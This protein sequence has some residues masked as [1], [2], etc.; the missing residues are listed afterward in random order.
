MCFPHM[1]RNL[2][3]SSSLNTWNRLKILS[4][5]VGLFGLTACQSVPINQEKLVRTLTV[6]GK[7]KVNIPTTMTQVNLGVQVQGKT[8]AEVQQQVA[9]KSSA[10]VELLKSRKEVEKLETAGINLNPDY[11]YKD[12]RQT[13]VGYSGSNIV[14]F[15]VPTEKTGTLLD[16]A[17]KAGATRID[18][19]SFVASDEAIAIAQKQALKNAV[20]DANKQADAVL[21]AL[22]LRNREIVNIQLNAVNP[23]QPIPMPA[24]AAEN[25]A[26]KQSM[27]D[28]PVV[29]GEREIEAFVTLQIKY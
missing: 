29:G 3:S 25:F 28:T 21:G 15:R 23:P 8:S 13:L 1:T 7:G 9:Q 11:S 27:R 17:I 20:E 10:V 4:L 12:G 26:S 16:E 6:P 5:V 18:G 2:L 24:I 22:N 19:L 14:K